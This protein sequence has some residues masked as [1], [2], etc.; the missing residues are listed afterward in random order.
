MPNSRAA[1]SEVPSAKDSQLD[2]GQP[3]THK[4]V[5]SQPHQGPQEYPSQTASP[6]AAGQPE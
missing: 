3:Q 4:P 6:D 5:G 1:A 2:R